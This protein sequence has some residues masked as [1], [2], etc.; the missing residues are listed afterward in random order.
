MHQLKRKNLQPEL[1]V[2]HQPNMHQRQRHGQQFVYS[3]GL[4][5]L[6]WLWWRKVV[7]ERTDPL[8]PQRASVCGLGKNKNRK[9]KKKKYNQ[10]SLQR[11]ILLHL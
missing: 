7:G 11:P 10:K 4:Q 5:E 1:H 6:R 8:S 9:K 2:L 3:L